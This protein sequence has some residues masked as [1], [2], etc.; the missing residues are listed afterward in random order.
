M[1]DLPLLLLLSY[2]LILLL[3]LLLYFLW[4]NPPLL[5]NLCHRFIM[6]DSENQFSPNPNPTP[7]FP[8][9]ARVGPE[10]YEPHL[11]SI[12]HE[13]E[14]WFGYL[15]G[16]FVDYRTISI[17]DMQTAINANWHL[18][19]PVTVRHQA[20][21]FYILEVETM[22]DYD[23]LLRSGPW[24]ING[25]LLQLRPW[26]ADR[27]LHSIDF[28]TA[29]MWVQISGAPLEYMTPTMAVRLG[30]LLG[31]VISVDRRTV[32]RENL[33]FMRVRVEIPIL[34]PFNP[35]CFSPPRER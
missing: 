27:A 6:D 16:R 7:P 3:T 10:V 9:H 22:A 31:T 25:A 5:P 24:N 34:R 15:V 33:E 12:H 14:R 11:P 2:L 8:L 26:V 28:S 32:D 1:S 21:R 29:T 30:S 13:R 35:G 17:H 20:G 4:L 18:D 23:D 19:G